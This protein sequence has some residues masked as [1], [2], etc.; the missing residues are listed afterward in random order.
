MEGA[1]C[2]LGVDVHS[3]ASTTEGDGR[4]SQRAPGPANG[5][6]E[7]NDGHCLQLRGRC[8]EVAPD[9]RSQKGNQGRTPSSARRFCTEA[10]NDVQQREFAALWTHVD[11]LQADFADQRRRMDASSSDQGMRPVS[12][13]TVAA[14]A[15]EVEMHTCAL[16]AIKL[17]CD[18]I[19]AH[20]KLPARLLHPA[21]SEDAEDCGDV[22]YVVDRTVERFTS[23]DTTTT[24]SLLN[25]RYS[26]DNSLASFAEQLAQ[27]KVRMLEESAVPVRSRLELLE[28]AARGHEQRLDSFG[29]T[30]SAMDQRLGC[31]S[32]EVGSNTSGLR[33]EVGHLKAHSSIVDERLAAFDEL[34]SRLNLQQALLTNQVSKQRECCESMDGNITSLRDQM[35]ALVDGLDAVTTCR[36]S[37]H[38]VETRK[39]DDIHKDSSDDRTKNHARLDQVFRFWKKR[40]SSAFQLEAAETNPSLDSDSA[41]TWVESQSPFSGFLGNQSTEISDHDEDWVS[42]ERFEW[43]LCQVRELEQHR[44]ELRDG[45]AAMQGELC[46]LQQLRCDFQLLS[47]TV[48]GLRSDADQLFSDTRDLQESSVVVAEKLVTLPALRD[49]LSLQTMKLG[50]QVTKVDEWRKCVDGSFSS[51]REE[52]VALFEGLEA[53]RS[54][55]CSRYELADLRRRVEDGMYSQHGG[56][57]AMPAVDAEKFRKQVVRFD[58]VLSFWRKRDVSREAEA[59][60]TAEGT[61]CETVDEPQAGSDRSCTG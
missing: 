25:L 35:V 58:N 30:L 32:D 22:T 26:V 6:V 27:L 34:E 17:Q 29:E 57:P 20:L 14:L 59:T 10:G 11:A 18:A 28:V 7:T 52:I 46:A 36:S 43:L 5:R 33:C 61:R 9:P 53:I 51:L 60:D 13:E 54:F 48:T 21:V 8:G 50:H 19:G 47:G 49:E 4:L 39:V 41:I 40:V 45:M 44:D 24:D 31:M 16:D 15:E 55:G 12:P 2:A 38:E 37:K 23:L 56:G 1:R 42:L 3:G